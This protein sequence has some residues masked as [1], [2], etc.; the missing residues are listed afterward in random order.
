VSRYHPLLVTLHWVLAILIIAESIGFFWLARR[1][2][3][4]RILRV[5][6]AGGMLNRAFVD[7]LFKPVAIMRA[8]ERG[9]ERIATSR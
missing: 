5:H 2:S 3:E 9:G 8:H 6:M 1:P 7:L 4:D